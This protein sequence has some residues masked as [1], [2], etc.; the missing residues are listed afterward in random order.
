MRERMNDLK[1]R[2]HWRPFGPLTHTDLGLWSPIGHL[3]RYMIG[4]ARLTDQGAGLLPA[5]T[6]ADGTTRPQRLAEGDEPFISAVLD[7]LVKRGHP[8][9]LLNTSFNGPA[10]PLVE[11]AVQALACARRLGADAL[12]TDEALL[13]VG[14]RA[15]VAR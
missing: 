9:V 8:P 12:V 15:A 14:D 2:E 5:V 1:R 4:A 3:E 6:H 10:Q 13:M 11:T 7:A